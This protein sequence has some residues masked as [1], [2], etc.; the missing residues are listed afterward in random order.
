MRDMLIA[1]SERR[2]CTMT[3]S[4]TGLQPKRPSGRYCQA[5]EQGDTNQSDKCI[6]SPTCVDERQ[7]AGVIALGM[8]LGSGPDHW[9]GSDSGPPLVGRQP[10]HQGFPLSLRN[11]SLP[12]QANQHS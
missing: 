10:L 8:G 9:G 1:T 6:E 12:L 7:Q 2:N 4:T 5:A 11:L 3:G